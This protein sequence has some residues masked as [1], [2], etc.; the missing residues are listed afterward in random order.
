MHTHTIDHTIDLLI[1]AAM[2]I[3]W[4]PTLAALEIRV[5]KGVTVRTRRLRVRVCE[6][7]TIDA[8]RRELLERP[9]TMLHLIAHG[10]ADA[11]IFEDEG[12]RGYPVDHE[13]LARLLLAH[14]PPLRYV[15][16]N[17]CHSDVLV[18]QLDVGGIAAIG[19]RGFGHAHGAIEFSRG[20]YDALVAR[21]SFAFAVEEGLR[22]CMLHGHALAVETTEAL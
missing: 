16:A 8:L 13:D 9:C 4:P 20:M 15:V 6:S 22:T 17:V 19:M 3:D 12:G 11:V 1:A 21:R 14:H 7:T 10:T 2:P 18:Q 5:I